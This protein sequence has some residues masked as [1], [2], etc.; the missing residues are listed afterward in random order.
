MKTLAY[1]LIYVLC[2]ALLVV[3]GFAVFLIVSDFSRDVLRI[4]EIVDRGTYSTIQAILAIG[5]YVGSFLVAIP[6][7]RRLVKVFSLRISHANSNP[8]L[9]S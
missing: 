8:S 9:P 2:V 5:I 7:T 6:I 4:H 3:L 1:I